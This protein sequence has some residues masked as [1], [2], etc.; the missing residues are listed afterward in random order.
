MS[1][2]PERRINLP[3]FRAISHAISTYEDVILLGK[4]ICESICRTFGIKASSVLVF[5]DRE[6]ELY[7]V[8]SEG[9]SSEYLEKQPVYLEGQF[10]EFTE[11]KP[12][13]FRNFQNDDRVQKPDAAIREGIVSMLSF[14]I[15]YR[16]DVVGLLK[17]YN[18][19]EWMIHEDDQDSINILAEQFGVVIENNG[20]KNFLDEVRAVMANLPLRMAGRF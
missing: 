10:K 14:P 9:L 18:T 1:Y 12:V 7:Y 20:L 11:G 5:D 8:C 3:Q 2:V 4:H 13:F 17:L 6:K 16:N 19:A 15:K